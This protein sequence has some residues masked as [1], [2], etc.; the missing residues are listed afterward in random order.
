MLRDYC[1][2]ALLLLSIPP[3]IKSSEDADDKAQTAD[4]EKSDTGTDLLDKEYGVKYASACE[5]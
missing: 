1:I 5:G 4:L 3:I 2:Y